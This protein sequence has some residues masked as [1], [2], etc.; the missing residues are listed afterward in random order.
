MTIQTSK[1]STP[2]LYK[3]DEVTQ[4]LNISRTVVFDLMRT[5]RLRSVHEGRARLIPASALS[6]YVERLQREAAG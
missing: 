6:E 4:L 2:L 1:L 3:V 5:G